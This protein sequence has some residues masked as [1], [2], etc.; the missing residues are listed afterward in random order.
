[1]TL[2]INNNYCSDQQLKDFKKKRRRCLKESREDDK[3]R[4]T[5][6]PLIVTELGELA[7]GKKNGLDYFFDL[8]KQCGKFLLDVQHITK[9]RGEKFPTKVFV[10]NALQSPQKD[11]TYNL[12]QNLGSFIQIRLD[13][14]LRESDTVCDIDQSVFNG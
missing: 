10:Y 2:P 4:K 3:D 7:R 6:H 14:L 11:S 8:Y 13:N 5:K 9:E 12:K 1:M